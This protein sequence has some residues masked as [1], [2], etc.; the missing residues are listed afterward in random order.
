MLS[1]EETTFISEIQ[2]NSYTNNDR[3]RKTFTCDVGAATGRGKRADLRGVI[4]E[5]KKM[6]IFESG[7]RRYYLYPADKNGV[8]IR[9]A[10]DRIQ[11]VGGATAPPV[12]RITRTQC[13]N[14][15]LP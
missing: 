10:G 7:F 6:S 3:I 9:V 14:S 5:R 8:A 4:S 11:R 1:G 12:G 13:E 2:S 15:I